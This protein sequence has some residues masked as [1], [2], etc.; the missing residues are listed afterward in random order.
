VRDKIARGWFALSAVVVLVGL[1]V[2]LVVTARTTGGV[3]DSPAAR[4]ANVF[5]FFTILSNIL[6]GGTSAAL[7]LRLN[8]PS[9]LFRTLRLDALIG[10][11]VTGVVFHIA[12]AGLHDLEGAAAL[13]DLLLH[14]VSPLLCVVGWLLF[15]PRPVITATI[16]PG[17]AGWSLAYPVLWLV[18]TLIR[19]AITDFYPYPFLDA[20]AHGYVRVALSC[21][22]VG[23]LFIGLAFGAMLLDRL[24]VRLDRQPV[25]VA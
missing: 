8:R 9:R 5:C 3:F 14:T 16:T 11:A 23:V 6:V 24:L 2:Q 22:I 25:T 17:I 13:A 12:L 19:G 1:V 7:A 20:H 4:V 21:V 10:I 18:F 15:G